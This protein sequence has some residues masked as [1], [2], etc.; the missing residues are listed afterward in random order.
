MGRNLQSEVISRTSS[1]SYALSPASEV[2]K[3]VVLEPRIAGALRY[4]AWVRPSG[5]QRPRFCIMSWTCIRSAAPRGCRVLASEDPWCS[6]P[7]CRATP[8]DSPQSVRGLLGTRLLFLDA[9]RP[10][11]FVRASRLQGRDHATPSRPGRR[12]YP[13]FSAVGDGRVHRRSSS[14]SIWHRGTLSSIL[15]CTF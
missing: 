2:R 12:V 3:V 5:R 9:L 8:K 14:P 4:D 7:P 15:R 6:P 11:G 10:R 13:E 1:G